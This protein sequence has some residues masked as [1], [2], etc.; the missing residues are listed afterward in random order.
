MD[1]KAICDA[2]PLY[3]RGRGS[4]INRLLRIMKLTLSIMLIACM[5]VSANGYGQT[6]TLSET[7]ASLNEIFPKIEKQSGYLFWYNDALLHEARKVNITVKNATLQQ[8]L[9]LCFQGQPFTYEII[10]KMVVLKTR[11]ALVMT[12]NPNPQMDIHGRVTDSLGMPLAGASVTI[13]GTNKG[14]K[15]NVKGEFDMNNVRSGMVLVIS[16]T[17]YVNKEVALSYG[18]GQVYVIMQRSTDILDA[19]VIQAYGTTSR[20]FSVGSISTVDAS[21]IEKQPVTNVLLALQGQVPGLAINATSGVPGSR[22]QLQVRGQNTM[23]SDPTGFKPYDQPLFIIDGVPFSPQNANISQLSNLAMG[24]TFNGGISQAGGLSPFNGINPA[25]IE[26][27]SILKDADATSI[28]GTQGSNGVILITTKKGKAGKTDFSLTANTGVNMVTRP[29]KLMNTQQYLQLRKDAFAND[30]ITP[31]SNPY[32]FPGYAPDLT[33]FD[34]NKYTN[35]EKVI[36]G[37]SAHNADIHASLSGGT[38]NNT[39]LMSLGYTHTGYTFPGADYADQRFTLHSNVHHASSDNRFLVELGIDYGYDVNNSPGSGAGAKV[40]L[41][42][43]TPDLLDGFQQYTMSGIAAAYPYAAFQQGHACRLFLFVSADIKMRTQYLDVHLIL[44][45]K[46]RL[47]SIRRHF[48]I[49][50]AG[51]DLNS[52]VSP[53][54]NSRETNGGRRIQPDLR[55]IGQYKSIGLPARCR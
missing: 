29:I 53:S 6:I 54:E 42:P 28:Y 45:D 38:T 44:S 40:L 49:S 33:I 47:L 3:R 4:S 22:V 21:T 52:P 8:V 46:K 9:D 32:A 51:Y 37:K 27:I 25:D 11:P 20:R 23:L 1:F 31:S 5:Q 10:D 50:L 7:N 12:E 24:S 26:S 19:T 15:T 39:F 43:N 55:T 34:Q 16:Y 30:G 13:K 36:Y 17:G 14:T 18:V 2:R 41:A 35:W 48:K